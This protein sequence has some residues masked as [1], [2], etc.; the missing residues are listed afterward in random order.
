MWPVVPFLSNGF[1]KSFIKLLISDT[2]LGLSR[3]FSRKDF[4]IKWPKDHQVFFYS[5]VRHFDGYLV[6][7]PH[8]AGQR[9]RPRRHTLLDILVKLQRL[10]CYQSIHWKIKQ[11]YLPNGL[12]KFLRCLFVMKWVEYS[13][14]QLDTKGFGRV[15]DV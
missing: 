12:N 7:N 6:R 3:V 4:L 1:I 13:I 11:F 9:R 14:L 5:G 2:F 10:Q 8:G 15:F